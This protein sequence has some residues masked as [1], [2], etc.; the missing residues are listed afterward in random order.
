MKEQLFLEGFEFDE[1][2]KKLE[3]EGF[4][5]PSIEKFLKDVE[6]Y[7]REHPSEPQEE[8]EPNIEPQE[9]EDSPQAQLATLNDELEV[10]Y[11]KQIPVQEVIREPQW[12]SSKNKIR[13]R[14]MKTMINELHDKA[15]EHEVKVEVVYQQRGLQT[16]TVYYHV[17]GYDDRIKRFNDEV[18]ALS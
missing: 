11:A 18:Y 3:E 15:L 9:L 12:I 4:D 14:N 6:R 17:W 2:H 1:A 8:P 16:H 7:E 13:G 5:I 10:M